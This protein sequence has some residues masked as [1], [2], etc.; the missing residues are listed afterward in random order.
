MDGQHVLT[1]T[2][3]P[4]RNLYMFPIP[5]RG[6]ASPVP[7]PRHTASNAYAIRPMATL[8]QY[9]H[10]TAGFPPLATFK[11]A[12]ANNAYMSWPG[13]RVQRVEPHLQD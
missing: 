5:T 11:E 8:I 1:G 2:M 4:A 3:D 12:I 6:I 13:L 7:H 9:L 10:A